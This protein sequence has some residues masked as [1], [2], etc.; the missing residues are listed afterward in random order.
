L[1]AEF[2]GVAGRPL[3]GF[4]PPIHRFPFGAHVILFRPD[5][6]GVVIVRVFRARMDWLRL[7]ERGWRGGCWSVPFWAKVS[8][9]AYLQ[10]VSCAMELAGMVRAAYLPA[11]GHF[12]DVQGSRT[13]GSTELHS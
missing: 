10:V 6:A 5:E 1:L 12:A 13:K 11:L 3:K 4:S 8:P 9:D 2:P 7:L